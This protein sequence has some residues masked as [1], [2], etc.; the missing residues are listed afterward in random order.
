MAPRHALRVD[1]PPHDPVN[2]SPDADM[3]SDY[4]SDS[5]SDLGVTDASNAPEGGFKKR[6][7]S[8]AYNQN[9]GDYSSDGRASLDTTGTGYTTMSASD[10][11]L[12][13]RSKDAKFDAKAESRL[14]DGFESGNDIIFAYQLL[15][16]KPKGWGKNQTLDI[17]EFHDKAAFLGDDEGNEE[18]E[19]VQVEKDTATT[20]VL[21]GCQE[22]IT[23]DDLD[24]DL[25]TWLFQSQV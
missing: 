1:D 15:R 14:S 8:N 25:Y 21:T 11:V 13:P 10:S 12:S 9:G 24:E 3:P 7:G 18:E 6:T 20:E 23:A 22:N 4:S 16:I 19:Q 5:S 2:P 17:D